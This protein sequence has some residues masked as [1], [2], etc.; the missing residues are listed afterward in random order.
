MGSGK[1]YYEVFIDVNGSNRPNVW[2]QDVYL[3]ALIKDRGLVP[4]GVDSCMMTDGSDFD[5]AGSKDL[6]GCAAKVIQY[7]KTE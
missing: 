6:Y 4:S 1:M 3:F 5:A 2:G 7:G